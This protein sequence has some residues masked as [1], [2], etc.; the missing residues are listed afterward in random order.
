[1][2]EDDKN[3]IIHQVVKGF[4]DKSYR[5]LL[6]AYQDFTEE[7]WE[8]CKRNNNDF[9]DIQDKQACEDGLTLVAIFALAD[10]LRDGIY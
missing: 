10:P 9:K 8:E 1:M 7:Q 5:T 2:E 3:R 6:V 4:A